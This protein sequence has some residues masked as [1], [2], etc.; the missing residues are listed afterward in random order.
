MTSLRYKWGQPLRRRFWYPLQGIRDIF[1]PFP[2]LA[3]AAVAVLFAKNAQLHEL[4]FSYMERPRL[5]HFVFAAA[6]FATVSGAIYAV[7]YWL[8]AV[9][10]NI[11]FAN[12]V[13]PNIGINFRRIRGLFGLVWAYLRELQWGCCSQNTNSGL[14]MNGSTGRSTN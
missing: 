7:H 4:Y 5:L 11:I 2:P 8:S 9:R 6:G 1:H 13:R 3:S 10:Q 12:F 14:G